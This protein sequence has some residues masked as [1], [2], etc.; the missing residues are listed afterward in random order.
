VKGLM[1]FLLDLSNL[2]ILI[3]F[4]TFSPLIIGE[5]QFFQTFYF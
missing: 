4:V 5:Q 2:H 1:W 3:G